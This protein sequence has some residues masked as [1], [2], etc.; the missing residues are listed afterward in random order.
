MWDQTFPEDIDGNSARYDKDIMLKKNHR[1]LIF[2]NNVWYYTML[3][4]RDLCTRFK[5]IFI[6]V[7]NDLEKSPRAFCTWHPGTL[8]DRQDMTRHITVKKWLNE[9]A[10]T[11]PWV[12]SRPKNDV[13]AFGTKDYLHSLTAYE[14]EWMWK[15]TGCVRKYSSGGDWK[16]DWIEQMSNSS[17]T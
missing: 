17:L 15:E 4:P 16:E 12:V 2:W 5:L 11:V 3:E 8:L 13:V 7:R 14:A 1:F 6:L 9:A 10:Y